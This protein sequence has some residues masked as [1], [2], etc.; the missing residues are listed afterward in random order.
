M[1]KLAIEDDQGHKTVVNLVRDEYTVGR[2][3]QNTIRLTERNISREHA[4][5]RRDGPVWFLHDRDSYNGCYT[6]GVRVTEPRAVEPG[7]LVQIGD[8]RLEIMDDSAASRPGLDSSPTSQPARQSLTGQPDRLVMLVGPNPG[9]EFCLP[10]EPVIIGRGEDCDIAISHGSVSR[11]HA[12]I[13]PLGDGRYEIIDRNSANGVRVNGVELQRAL[14]DARDTIELGDIVLKFIP[15]GDIYRPGAD[16]SERIA[17]FVDA[18]QPIPTVPAG[19]DVPL[20]SAPVLTPGRIAAVG[21]AIVLAL[22]LGILIVGRSEQQSTPEQPPATEGATAA[23]TEAQ[24]LLTNGEV[25]AAHIRLVTGVPDTSN[26]RES[27]EFRAIEAQWA[28][29]LFA[30]AQRETNREAKR[31]L[32]ERITQAPSVDSERRSRAADL[33]AE[34]DGGEVDISQLP[35]ADSTDEPT[36]SAS[37]SAAEP[38]AAA[39]PT[40]SPPPPTPVAEAPRRQP[41]APATHTVQPQRPPSSSQSPPPSTRNVRSDALS[42]DRNAQL[43]AIAALKAKKS[44]GTISDQ[45]RRLLRALCRQHGDASC[46]N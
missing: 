39:P 37:D 35:Q 10:G 18:P 17:P 44:A 46:A 33:I 9:V 7:D 4:V 13:Q 32:L 15:E 41:A 42:R 6:N 1:W 30:R 40:P 36:P 16:E 34:L 26:V 19:G 43:R 38:A 8:Y 5:L 45:E 22:I 21:G 28:D 24:A 27:D 2:A 20:S 11:V 23:L 12:E 14:L 25:E 31:S 29:S 3:Q